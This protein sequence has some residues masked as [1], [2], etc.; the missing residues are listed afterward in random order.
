MR[1]ELQAVAEALLY[2][3]LKRGVVGVRRG[4]RGGDV[5]RAADYLHAVIRVGEAVVIN[6]ALIAAASCGRAGNAWRRGIR[7]GCRQVSR[8][9]GKPWLVYVVT[10]GFTGID[11]FG[12]VADN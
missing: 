7:I 10:V 3:C 8:R 9:G 6:P 4:S 12:N 11:A 5:L 1:V 2:G